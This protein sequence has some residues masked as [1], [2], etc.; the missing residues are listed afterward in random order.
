M[1]KMKL[2]KTSVHVPMLCHVKKMT[3]NQSIISFHF[4]LFSH[5]VLRLLAEGKAKAT[6]P[7]L[8]IPNSTDNILPRCSRLC[9]CWFR[10]VQSSTNFRKDALGQYQRP[11]NP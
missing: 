7:R 5:H 3:G 9:R 11:E 6:T 2:I 8:C 1:N 4:E 10:T